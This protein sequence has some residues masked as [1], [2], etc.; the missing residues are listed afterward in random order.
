[1]SRNT[2]RPLSPHLTIWKWGPHMAVSII[3][4]VTGGA[5]ATVG[6][7]VLVLWLLAI[8]GG[9]ESYAFFMEHATAWYGM[10]VIIGLSWAWIFHLVAGFRHFVMDVGAGFELNTNRTWAWVTILSSFLLTGLLWLIVF[11]KGL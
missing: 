1:M 7:L 6:V 9:P 3:N 11:A 8:A 5:L 2:A 4:R 10:V